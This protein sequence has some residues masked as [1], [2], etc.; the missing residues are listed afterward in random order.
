MH[1]SRRHVAIRTLQP[2]AHG[3]LENDIAQ[4]LNPTA[5]GPVPSTGKPAT[6]PP[7][8]QLPDASPPHDAPPPPRPTRVESDPAT[9]GQPSTITLPAAELLSHCETPTHDPLA[10]WSLDSNALQALLTQCPILGSSGNLESLRIIGDI[11]LATAILS[12]LPPDYPV[13]VALYGGANILLDRL[14]LLLRAPTS[15]EAIEHELSCHTHLL[16]SGTLRDSDVAAYLGVS[17]AAIR[18]ARSRKGSRK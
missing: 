6:E 13:T 11:N 10:G 3:W 1:D 5:I 2:V 12:R 4:W 17:E 9:H 7:P 16:P 8:S 15:T 14:D 18:K